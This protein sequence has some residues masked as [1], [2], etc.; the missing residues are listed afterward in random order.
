[1]I[2]NRRI[3]CASLLI[4]CVFVF[5]VTCEAVEQTSLDR[6]YESLKRVERVIL[7]SGA[8]KPARTQLREVRDCFRSA[9]D[10]GAT[11]LIKKL[12]E[13]NSEVINIQRPGTQND[14]T[15]DNLAE[16]ATPE[17]GIERT[18]L[19]LILA[20]TFAHTSTEVQS[21]ILAE[22]R[23]SVDPSVVLGEDIDFLIRAFARIGPA[24]VPSLLQLADSPEEYVRCKVSS[25][26]EDL[27]HQLVAAPGGPIPSPPNL[28]CRE[29]V[30]KR[31]SAISDWQKWWSDYGQS[32]QFPEIK[33]LFDSIEQ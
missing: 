24:S 18:Y 7:H 30:E 3:K 8:D 23:A 16:W 5:Q 19:A 22:L 25:N 11:F 31:E 9:G 27:G 26:L 4:I 2:S 6:C 33:S 29:N 14:T 1:M 15:K 28:L 21:L 32:R 12:N 13:M 20:D 17:R 10:A